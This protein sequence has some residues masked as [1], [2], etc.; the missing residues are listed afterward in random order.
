[1]RLTKRMCERAREN[2]WPRLEQSVFT[3]I[4]PE[5]QLVYHD[6]IGTASMLRARWDRRIHAFGEEEERSAI[7][8]QDA[9]QW[10]NENHWCAIPELVP[11]LDP[12][13]TA[14]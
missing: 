12:R 6:M 7:L 9:G 2:T 14:R 11:A 8:Q 10:H 1:M 4:S 3:I 13:V 5:E